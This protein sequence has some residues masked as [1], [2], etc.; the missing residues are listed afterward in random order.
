LRSIAVCSKG[1]EAVAREPFEKHPDMILRLNDISVFVAN[2]ESKV[3]NII[4]IQAT[5]NIGFDSMVF[6]DDSRFER[7]LVRQHL[8]EVYVPEMPEYPAEYLP[9]LYSLNLFETAFF[10]RKTQSEQNFIS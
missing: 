9:F 4:A 10:L 3:E 7:N 1:D 2:W 6:I 5:L 8:K